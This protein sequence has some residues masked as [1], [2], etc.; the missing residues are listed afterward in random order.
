MA[1][2]QGASIGWAPSMYMTMKPHA[3]ALAERL[4]IAT[5]KADSI[6]EA[7]ADVI[8]LMVGADDLG[9]AEGACGDIGGGV[10]R[11]VACVDSDGEAAIL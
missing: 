1:N 8:G 6:G 9:E 3:V 2:Y 4:E 10:R 11:Q 7:A 5:R